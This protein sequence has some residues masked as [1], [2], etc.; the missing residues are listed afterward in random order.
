M[1]EPTQRQNSGCDDWFG[2]AFSVFAESHK[3]AP[4]WIRHLGCEWLYRLCQEPLRLFS[5]Y[6]TTIPIFMWLALKQILNLA[7]IRISE[8]PKH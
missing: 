1:D 5:R 3:R 6:M 8:F 4:Y 2:G 7:L